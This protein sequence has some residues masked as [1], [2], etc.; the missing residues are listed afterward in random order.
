DLPNFVHDFGYRGLKLGLQG[1]VRMET[2]VLYFYSSRQMDAQVKVSFPRGL[3]TEWYPQAEYEA[4][5]LAPAEGRPVQ[6]T[7]NNVA[8]C[9]KCHMS[10]NGIDTSLQTL[11]GTLE[12]NRVHI[13]PG[14]QPPFP[15][16]ES[17]NRYYAARVTDAAPLTVGD[18]HEKFLFY[19]GVGTFPIPLSARVRE[20]GKITLANFGG[21]P[22]PS[23]ILFENR[24]GHI[25]YRMAG[26]LEKEGTLDA[27]RLDASFARLRQDLEAALVSQGLFPKEAHAMLE[28][29]RDSWFEEGSRLIYLVPRTTVDI[30]LPL[31]IEPAPSEIA[32][33]FIGRIELLTPETKRTV[34]A[35]FRTG[36]WQVAARYQRLLTPIL[37]RIFAADPASRNEL[38]PRAAAL[39]AAHQGEVC[40]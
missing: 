28:T 29:W 24:G 6:L 27:P 32:R 3:L 7:P 25:G 13:N 18:Q 17:P 4:H 20:S 21:E 36:D 35:A 2:P 8:G 16:E 39:L 11:T 1:S 23:V 37:G 30:I 10:L 9:T 5:Q 15:T 12:W 22:V 31:H 38:A 26:T 19:R 14:T 40:K 33:V 34:E